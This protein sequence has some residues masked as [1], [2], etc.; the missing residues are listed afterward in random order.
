M[1]CLSVAGQYE[2]SIIAVDDEF[3]GRRVLAL[4][5]RNELLQALLGM[6]HLGEFSRANIVLLQVVVNP[7]LQVIQLS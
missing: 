1:I 3:D 6:H 2:I 7:H 5:S 4:V